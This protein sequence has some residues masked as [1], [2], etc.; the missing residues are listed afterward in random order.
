[1]SKQ[2]R[3]KV[4]KSM[5]EGTL[6]AIYLATNISFRLRRSES[7]GFY[8]IIRGEAYQVKDELTLREAYQFADGLL[9]AVDNCLSSID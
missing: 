2:K 1:M 6:T 5:V 8:Q 3:F 9:H 4:T 7:E